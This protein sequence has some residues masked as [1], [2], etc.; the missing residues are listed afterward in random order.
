MHSVLFRLGPIPIRAYGFMLWMGLVMGLVLTL[1]RA[2]SSAITPN[3]VVDI[4][5]YGLLAGILSAHLTSILLD[6]EYFASNPHEIL[7]LWR[8]VL[9]PAGGLRGL[10]F[11]GGLT[12][13]VLVTFFYCKRKHISFL[14]VADLFSPGLALGY[15]ITR[16]GCFLNGCCYGTPTTMPW[17]VRFPIVPGASELTPPSHPT[18]L[19][20]AVA[21]LLIMAWLLRREKHRHVAGEV[22]AS[23]LW[24]YSL[25]RF[26]IEFLRRGVTAKVAIDGLTQAQVVSI[27][28]MVVT[29][30]MMY[31]VNRRTRGLWNDR[32]LGT[33][34]QSHCPK[35]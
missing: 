16:L 15:A 33:G 3:Q 30:V 2:R 14:E 27:L 20:A 29:L 7:A 28:I 10:S 32:R 34:I 18:Q 35:R 8:N 4:A 5:L 25:Y 9:S 1:R 12:G 23:Y 13:G 19:Y 24:V 26:L 11:H 6:L 17:G 31:R 21:N 22:F